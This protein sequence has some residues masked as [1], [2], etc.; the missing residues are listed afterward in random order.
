MID[1]AILD[2]IKEYSYG[3]LSFIDEKGCPF[4]IPLIFQQRG[5]TLVVR[6][7]KSLAYDFVEP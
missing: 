7:P 2:E 5:E 3:V 4:S 6:K 1:K